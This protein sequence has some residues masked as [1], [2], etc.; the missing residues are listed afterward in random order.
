MGNENDDQLKD[1]SANSWAQGKT[2]QGNNGDDD[3]DGGGGNGGDDDGNGGDD[4]DGS[5]ASGPPGPTGHSGVQGAT[6][7]TGPS[8]PSGASGPDSEEELKKKL[9]LVDQTPGATGP[10]PLTQD[11]KSIAEMLGLKPEKDITADEL[12]VLIKETQ[13]PEDEDLKDLISEFKELKEKNPESDILDVALKIHNPFKHA[14]TNMS[15]EGRYS[16]YLQ[17]SLNL[18]PEKAREEINRLVNNGEFDVKIAELD[19]A[20]KTEADKLELKRKSEKEKIVNDNL[21]KKADNRKA[22]AEVILGTKALF[23]GRILIDNESKVKAHQMVTSGE[24]RKKLEDHNVVFKVA[25]FLENEAKI[26]EVLQNLGTEKGK[27]AYLNKLE[28]SGFS[29]PANPGSF[30]G[31]GDFNADAWVQK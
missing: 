3:D 10:A 16:H 14:L 8:G 28:N 9:G 27:A 22:L 11:F 25:F 31:K 24:L 4:G 30:D 17:S 13:L 21:K 6:G 23:D 1:F 18:T 29:G 15:K 20:L 5:G 19:K 26:V 2:N 12:K 7:A